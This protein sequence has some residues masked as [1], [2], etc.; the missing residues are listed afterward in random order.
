[1][2]FGTVWQQRCHTVSNTFIMILKY[3]DLLIITSEEWK[4]TAGSNSTYCQLCRHCRSTDIMSLIVREGM[5]QQRRKKYGS[6]IVLPSEKLQEEIW[7]SGSHRRKQRLKEKSPGDL[8]KTESVF[9]SNARFVF[10]TIK[11][12]WCCFSFQKQNRGFA[13]VL[14]WISGKE[15]STEQQIS[16]EAVWQ[17]KLD[18][19]A[20][21]HTV[22]H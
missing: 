18:L 14:Q 9:F 20:S 22:Q 21:S 12:A 15:T 4:I 5:L 6:I 7:S 10:L 13:M 19:R 2:L 3:P 1:M 11:I 17:T 8:K 16:Q